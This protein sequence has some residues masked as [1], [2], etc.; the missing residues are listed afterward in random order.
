MLRDRDKFS[1]LN[2]LKNISMRPD[3]AGVCGIT[4]EEML[5]AMTDYID[6]FAE[7]QQTTKKSRAE[8]IKH[9]LNS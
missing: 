6:D 1:E 2:N 9:I 4:E 3:Y 7:A 5:T 8:T